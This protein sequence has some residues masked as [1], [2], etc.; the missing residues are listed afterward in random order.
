MKKTL[1]LL[2]ALS[3][4]TSL[5]PASSKRKRPQA[6]QVAPQAKKQAVV[7]PTPTGYVL[8]KIMARVNGTPVLLSDL[9]Q[10][11]IDRNGE[12]LLT[13]DD[14][15]FKREH[16]IKKALEQA[17]DDELL[18]HRALDRQLLPSEL[19]IEKQIVSLKAMQGLTHLTT[20]QF[21][22]QLAGEGLTMRSYR[23]QLRRVLATEKL[24]Q[25]E[26][27]ERLVT[28]TQ[29]L[30]EQFEKSPQKQEESFRLKTATFDDSLFQKEGE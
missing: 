9:L 18:F 30:R 28:T 20:E 21:E 8:D 7:P 25:T 27:S 15:D 12:A 22:E 10:R 17:I 3:F 2:L 13:R 6:G 23:V 26:M 5:S 1:A 24:R 4:I 29:E 11:R 14:Y 16:L 19:E